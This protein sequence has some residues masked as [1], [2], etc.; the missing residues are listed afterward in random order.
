MAGLTI[1]TNLPEVQAKLGRIGR[2]QVPFAT[3]LA[4]TRTAQDGQEAVRSELPR[5]FTLRSSWLQRGIRVQ[6]AN[7]ARPVARVWSRD[8]FM[9][10]QEVGGTKSPRGRAIA[11]PK[12]IRRSERS[13]IPRSRRPR[14]I[15]RRP[16]T[17]V[18]PLRGGD[19][20]IF[21]RR[22]RRGAVRLLY[23]LE[24]DP[25][26]IDPRW[27]FRSTVQDVVDRTFAGHFGRAL[28]RALA[29]AR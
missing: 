8:A 5:R 23:A 25:V 2:R 26:R 19:A 7:K 24:T 14:A 9:V 16:R 18:A 20:G 1:D 17:F 13:R 12:A 3:V 21:Q 15:L 6:A 10:L 4:L 11:I 27:G 28:A 29:T 22:G